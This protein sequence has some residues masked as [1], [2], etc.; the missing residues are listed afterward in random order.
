MVFVNP[1][2]R[3]LLSV[4]LVM[5][6]TTALGAFYERSSVSAAV[7]IQTW[8]TDLALA[9][10]DN[11]IGTPTAFTGPSWQGYEDED[12]TA[13]LS[14]P[15]ERQ[16]MRVGYHVQADPYS[17]QPSIIL[18]DAVMPPVTLAGRAF[19]EFWERI[20]GDYVHFYS[21]PNLRLLLG[22]IGVAAILANCDLDDDFAHAYQNQVRSSGTDTASAI[23]E[24]LGRGAY[25]I[26]AFAAATLLE[27]WY[28]NQSGQTTLL[29]EWSENTFR[30][31]LVGGPPVF[32]L[33]PLLG[34]SRP[35]EMAG[36]KWKPFSGNNGVSGHAFLGAVPFLSAAMMTDNCLLKTTLIGAS[37][38]TG[39]SRINDNKHFLSQVLLGWWIAYLSTMSV[40]QT[41]LEVAGFQLEPA[42]FDNGY[43]VQATYTW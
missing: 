21:W 9:A 2:R 30:A 18:D 36:S 39:W 15:G 10:D 33:Q 31:M 32:I 11:V 20:K 8:C 3:W 34:A 22:G 42:I 23:F 40:H 16:V 38:L 27:L 43:G 6:A 12:D 24:K 4:A 37:T 29:G 41:N 17:A 1:C 28:E 19:P 5:S 7:S 25:V 26:P 14:L 35:T 13:D